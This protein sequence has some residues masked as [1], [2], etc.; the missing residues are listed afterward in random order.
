MYPNVYT[1][2]MA[3]IAVLENAF[4]VGYQ[5]KLN[6]LWTATFSMP[7]DDPKTKLLKPYTIIEI[8]DDEERIDIFRILPESATIDEST[9]VI[10]YECEHVLGT[11]IDDILFQYHE[12]INLS[13][14]EIIEYVLSYQTKQRWVLGTVEFNYYYSHKWESENLLGSLFSIPTV[15]IEDYKWVWD[16]TRLPWVINLMQQPTDVKT[17]IRYGR[18]MQNIVRTINPTDLVTRLYGLGYGEGV[19]QLTVSSVNNGVPYIDSDTKDTYGIVSKIFTDTTEE[20]AAALLNKMRAYL[21]RAKI[22]RYEYSIDVAHIYQ[23]TKNSF[24][25]F[26]IGEYCTVVD[27]IDDVE[28]TARVVGI[29]K[30]DIFDDP[31]NATLEIANSPED[32]ASDVASIS[33]RQRIHEVY[34][35]GS[36]NLFT[37]NY[38]DNCDSSNPA[39]IKFH[40]PN[41]TVYINKIILNY[42]TGRFR[43]YLRSIQSDGSYSG[44]TGS[45]SGNAST[46]SDGSYSGSTGSWSGSATTESGGDHGHSVSAFT[47]ASNGGNHTHTV[48]SYG[49][50]GNAGDHTHTITAPTIGTASI[51]IANGGVHSHTI[52]MTT[53]YF[54]GKNGAHSHTV[55]GTVTNAVSDHDHTVSNSISVDSGSHTHSNTAHTHTITAPTANTTGSHSHVMGTVNISSSTHTH[56]ITAHSTAN[57]GSHTHSVSIPSHTHSISISSHSHSVSIPSHTHSISI[58]THSHSIDHGIFLYSANPSYVTIVVDGSTIAETALN[59]DD[60]NVVAYLSKDNDGKINRG[61]HEIQIRPNTLARVEAALAAQIFIQSRGGG[62]Y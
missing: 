25:D 27:T 7:Y 45:W 31:G 49:A 20:D 35:Q 28:F 59:R 44:N 61:W 10:N 1:P 6:S 9:K 15:F 58:G 21:E 56:E 38:S 50:M 57:A 39:I 4:G 53:S 17:Y 40:I 14:R 41:E 62:L 32:I 26:Y 29:S 12:Q 33:D 52:Q 55:S 5:K 3:F 48:G 18:N 22:P 51:T 34:S 2:D 54:T 30:P 46:S 43:A 60:L 19:N 37:N 8:F 24:D 36:T 42:K 16:T 11:L 13:T 23:I 47:T